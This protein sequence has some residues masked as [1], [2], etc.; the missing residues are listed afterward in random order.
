[1]MGDDSTGP[2]SMEGQQC[3]LNVW[4]R[5]EVK[6]ELHRVGEVCSGKRMRVNKQLYY[7]NHS[8]G[9]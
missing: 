4:T 3:V 8:S 9:I 2:G 7:P 5:R 6:E 1:M